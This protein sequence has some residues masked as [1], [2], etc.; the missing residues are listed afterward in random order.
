MAVERV[1]GFCPECGGSEVYADT[2]GDSTEI[3]CEDCGHTGTA[4]RGDK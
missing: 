2:N 1:R 4:R 3:V